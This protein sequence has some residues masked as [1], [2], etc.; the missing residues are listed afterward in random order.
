MAM[1]LNM[2]MYARFSSVWEVALTLYGSSY[3]GPNCLWSV[4]YSCLQEL[5]TMH[6]LTLHRVLES[7]DN[8]GRTH[9]TLL[10]T[11]QKFYIANS[12]SV[13][14]MCKINCQRPL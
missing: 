8:F 13:V 1:S 12:L 9:T 3:T 2:F 7:G 4:L 6:I 10:V 11:L 5:S 14:F